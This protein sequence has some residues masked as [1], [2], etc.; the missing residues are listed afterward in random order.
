MELINLE[1]LKFGE[2]GYEI[3]LISE[4]SRWHP[5]VGSFDLGRVT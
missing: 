5:Q 3:S 1:G 2:R 4:A